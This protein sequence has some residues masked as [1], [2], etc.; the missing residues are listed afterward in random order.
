MEGKE[1]S[2]DGIQMRKGFYKDPKTL[3]SNNHCGKD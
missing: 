3:I 2:D 1:G